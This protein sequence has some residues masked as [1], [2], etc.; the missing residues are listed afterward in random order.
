MELRKARLA[1]FSVEPAGALRAGRA[2][3]ARS[4]C[5]RR[6]PEA[7]RRG[8][9]LPRRACMIGSSAVSMSVRRK[10]WRECSGRGGEGFK[11]GLSAENYMAITGTSPATATRD[12]ANLVAKWVLTRTGER[13]HTRYWLNN[14]GAR[15]QPA[16][17][18][19]LRPKRPVRTGCEQHLA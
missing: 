17:V 15:P 8:S 1:K 19:A 16:S 4:G 14:D 18:R 11:G 9:E 7:C 2:V 12:L 10:Y 3:S 6:R 5:L 13:R